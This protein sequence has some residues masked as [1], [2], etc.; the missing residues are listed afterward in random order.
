M[1][2]P[3]EVRRVVEALMKSYCEGAFAGMDVGQIRLSYG[4]RGSSVTLYEE[5]PP[6]TGQGEW[7]KMAVAQFRYGQDGC[8]TLY[9]ADRNSRWH[10][11]YDV[12]PTEDIG[13]LLEEVTDDPTGIFWG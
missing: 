8:W 10:E 6:Y 1:A 3:E 12:D 9:C 2:L 4:V 5:R 13:E 11:Y 7:S